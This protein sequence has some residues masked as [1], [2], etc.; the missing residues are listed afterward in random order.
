MSSNVM[1]FYLFF[2]S[3]T[4]NLHYKLYYFFKFYQYFSKLV[5]HNINYKLIICKSFLIYKQHPKKPTEELNPGWK[6]F[7]LKI[8]FLDSQTYVYPSEEDAGAGTMDCFFFTCNVVSS[9]KE[10]PLGTDKGKSYVRKQT[11]AKRLPI[12]TY[13]F[14]LLWQTVFFMPSFYHFYKHIN[15]PFHLSLFP[16]IL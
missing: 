4:K 11:S 6:D 7:I 8:Y 12:I 1:L 15:V 16:N 14:F 2:N 3:F 13:Y 9:D 5:N 10:F